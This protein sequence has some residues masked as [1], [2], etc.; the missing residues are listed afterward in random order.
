MLYARFVGPLRVFYSASDGETA[1]RTRW[2]D[3][4]HLSRKHRRLHWAQR[5]VF[6]WHESRVGKGARVTC[7]TSAVDRDALL[8]INRTGRFVVV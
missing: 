8:R 3:A 2:Y 1:K 4:E 5:Q 6:G 7:A